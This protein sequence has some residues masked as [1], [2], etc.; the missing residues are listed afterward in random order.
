M[1]NQAGNLNLWNF[2][3]KSDEENDLL[4]IVDESTTY[5]DFEKNVKM[6]SRGFGIK[7]NKI[8]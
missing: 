2:N 7:R 8:K 5:F 6:G 4:K 1:I 3:F